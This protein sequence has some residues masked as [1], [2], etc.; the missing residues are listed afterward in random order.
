MDF[1]KQ[2]IVV[3]PPYL[4]DPVSALTQKHGAPSNVY[5]ALKVYKSQC[6]EP[7]VIKDQVRKAH[8]ELVGK[9]FMKKISEFPDSVISV[10]QSSLFQHYYCCM[11]AV[12]KEDS[13]STPVGLVVDPT[14][15]GLNLLLAKGENTLGNIIDIL[16]R[17]RTRQFSWASDISK[18]YNQLHL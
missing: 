4:S 6:R 13:L 7:E 14:C 18:L 2:R 15:A 9:G 11:R 17:N 3:Q 8:S 1:E 5:Q 10:I 16:V 12:F